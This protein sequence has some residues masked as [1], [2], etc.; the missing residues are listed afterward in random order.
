MSHYTTILFLAYQL[1]VFLK[2]FFA[3]LKS[4][5][6]CFAV[7]TYVPC[8]LFFDTIFSK[9]LLINSGD[10]ETNP[11]PRKSSP[12]KFCHFIKVLLIEAFI[13][14]HNLDILCLSE[15]VLDSAIDLND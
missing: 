9:I 12:N 6:P 15:T 7:F 1:P 3:I 8:Y 11:G 2:G 10:D 5:T 14:T 4:V 13:S